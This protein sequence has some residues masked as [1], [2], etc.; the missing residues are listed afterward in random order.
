MEEVHITWQWVAGGALAS[1][2]V[3]LIYVVGR[4]AKAQDLAKKEN[5]DAHDR[6]LFELRKDHDRGLAI[7]GRVS[8]IE[9]L[10]QERHGVG[11]RADDVQRARVCGELPES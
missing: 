10:C 3:V 8:V 11:R 4:A 1:L 2:Q 9:Q 6:I 7:L 5:A